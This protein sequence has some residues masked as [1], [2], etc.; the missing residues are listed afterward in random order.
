[1]VKKIVWVFIALAVFC[2]HMQVVHAAN[3]NLPLENNSPEFEA[4]IIRIYENKN[5][6]ESIANLGRYVIEIKVLNGREKG[7]TLTAYGIDKPTPASRSYRAGDKVLATIITYPNNETQV[8]VLDYMRKDALLILFLLFIIIS[9]IAAKKRGI[10]SLIGMAYTFFV[11]FKFVLP[12]I[13]AGANPVFIAILGSVAIIPVTYYVSHGIGIKTHAAVLGTLISLILTGVLSYFFVN[14]SHLT[15]IASEESAFIAIYKP[16]YMKGLLMAGIIIG[17]L[18]ILDDITISQAA[19]VAKLKETDP[20]LGFVSLYVKAIDIGRDHIGSV[21]NTL[22]LVYAG[23]SLPLLLLFITNNQSFSSVVN[24]ELIAEEIV[25]TLTASI[26][27]IM[28][29]PITT[30]IAAIFTHKH[31]K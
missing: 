16:I 5:K 1:M 3:P 23:A 31:R 13:L 20:K 19:I 25:R 14:L 30:A 6:N 12:Q 17:L 8:F 27:L 11:I 10:L 2:S 18:G 24:Y 15:G 7:K 26:G 21:I 4:Q 28:A 29:V 22:V 9:A